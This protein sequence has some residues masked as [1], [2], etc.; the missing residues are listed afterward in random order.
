MNIYGDDYTL[1]EAY[2]DVARD[3]IS[4]NAI[5][6]NEFKH[7]AVLLFEN[8]QRTFRRTNPAPNLNE[9]WF[10]PITPLFRGVDCA[11]PLIDFSGKLLICDK[12][13]AHQVGISNNMLVRIAGIGLG[14]TEDGRANVSSIAAY[15]HLKE[16]YNIACEQAN[17]DFAVEYLAGKALLETYTCYPVVPMAFLLS[18][19]I[20]SLVNDILSILHQYEVTITG[21]MNL[22]RAPWNNPALNALITMHHLLRE[23]PVKIGSVHGNGGMGFSQGVTI[24]RAY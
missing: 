16:A 6:E 2:S 7:L 17:T 12:P 10:E 9:K 14:Y 13:L 8:Y 23:G 1:P 19:G 21:G 20:A 15:N 24:L 22:A 11:N 4:K 5:T 3:F 18:S